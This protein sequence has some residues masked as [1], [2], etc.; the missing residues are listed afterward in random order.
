MLNIQKSVKHKHPPKWVLTFAKIICYAKD[1]ISENYKCKIIGFGC[2]FL[3]NF[4][5]AQFW[6]FSN[7]EKCI[8][9]PKK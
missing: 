1:V 2:H 5:M 8:L 7:K 3:R 6:A 4:G 9:L